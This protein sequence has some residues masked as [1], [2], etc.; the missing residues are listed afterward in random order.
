MTNAGPDSNRPTHARRDALTWHLAFLVLP[1]QDSQT[2][3]EREDTMLTFLNK[4]PGFLLHPKLDRVGVLLASAIWIGHCYV[5]YIYDL[6]F[7]PNELITHEALGYRWIP[8]AIVLIAFQTRLST[9]SFHTIL[10][11]LLYLGVG[12]ATFTVHLGIIGWGIIDLS[13]FGLYYGGLGCLVFLR[14]MQRNAMR[15]TKTIRDNMH[16]FDLA[17]ITEFKNDWQILLSRLLK[18]VLAI[19]MVL[20]VCMSIL[21]ASGANDDVGNDIV[22]WHDVSRMINATRL[23]ILFILEFLVYF[24]FLFLPLLEGAGVYQDLIIRSRMNDRG[25]V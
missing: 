16:R 9:L 4:R 11:M 8:G 24:V 7:L 18:V 12:I 10:D 1:L 6:L 20:G 25:A 14:R 17:C 23:A 5:P 21:L 3:C 13:W 19:V 15:H 22:A 2:S